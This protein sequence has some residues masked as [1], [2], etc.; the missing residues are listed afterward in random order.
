MALVIGE[1]TVS[2]ARLQNES[3]A[4]A[5]QKVLEFTERGLG[6]YQNVLAAVRAMLGTLAANPRLVPV[7]SFSASPQTGEIM[8]APD[9]A[10]TPSTPEICA[11]L[12]DVLK[13]VPAVESLSV[14]AANGVVRCSTVANAAGL[15]L[16]T[17][18]YFRIAMLGIAYVDTVPRSYITGH[19]GIYAAQPLIGPS[20][21]VAGALTARVDVAEL[22]PRDIISGLGPSSQMMIVDPAGVVMAVYPD[23]PEL[24]GKDLRALDFVGLS[25]SRTRG[26]IST[27]GMDG[28]RRIYGFSRLPDSNMHLLVG[29]DRDV[30]LAPIKSATWR[31]ALTL[32]AAS[33]IIFLGLWVAGERLVVNPVRSLAERLQR[34]GQGDAGAREGGGSPRRVAE[35][36]PLTAAFEAMA[37]ELTARESELRNT[38]SRLSDLASLDPLTGIANRR[39]FDVAA[40]F[41][42]SAETQLGMLIVDIDE[43]KKYNDTFGHKEGD[44]SL[45]KV[46]Q[47]MAAALRGT[48]VVARLG[49]EEFAVLMPGASM[50]A[51]GEAAERLRREVERLAI[52]HPSLPDGV[53][54]VSIGC[55]ACEP[56]PELSLSDLFVAAD[57]A[58]Y[59]AKTSGR[60]RVRFADGVS[61]NVISKLPNPR[62]EGGRAAEG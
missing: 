31:A 21:R 20:G 59:A 42:W 19:P 27:N 50:R 40:A 33:L 48:D 43:F 15:E 16:S 26:T 34:F 1:R 53:L 56:S 4:A 32:L 57:R 30:I 25:L 55:A 36:E 3:L 39:S 8:Q 10:L 14:V 41:C 9:A 13:V 11:Q 62:D 54:T 18:D 46:A 17:R 7:D 60:N 45:R 44:H 58:L 23:Q 22:F 35:L 12:N 28:V 38:N 51:A 37:N 5:E 52:P 6:Q 24:I 29:V 61:A 49:G 47:V 2:I